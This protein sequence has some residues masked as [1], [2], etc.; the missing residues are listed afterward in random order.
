VRKIPTVFCRVLED[1]D[2]LSRDVHPDCWWVIN[3]EGRATRKTDGTC[4]LLS[5]DGSWWARRQVKPDKI[6]PNAWIEIEADPVTGKRFG[7]EPIEQSPYL[8]PF[9]E[10]TPRRKPT[11]YELI[12][13]KVNSNPHRLDK[14]QLVEH[15]ANYFTSREELAEVPRDYDGLRDWLAAHADP[16]LPGGP[17]EGIV[18]HHEDGRMAKIKHRDVMDA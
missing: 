15:G 12:G 5:E 1:M 10:A 2:R 8:A 3:G 7:W 6:P 14:H 16:E 11:T 18:F 13:P 9:Q 4:L 17:W